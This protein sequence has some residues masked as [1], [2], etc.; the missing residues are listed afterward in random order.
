MKIYA[1]LIIIVLVGG[2]LYYVSNLQANLAIAKENV[3]KLE[4]AVAQQKEVME[5]MEADMKDIRAANDELRAIERDNVKKEEKLAKVFNQ[6]KSGAARD[7]GYLANAKPG[8]IEKVINK[9]SIQAVRCLEIATG[10][11][12]TQSELN[13]SK[14][15]EINKACPEI[16]NPNYVPP[17][18]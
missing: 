10:S 3:V 14:Y 15:N 7:I 17:L 6:S 13:A 11:E 2:G 5:M 4:N 16:A 1:L 18:K 12:L 9:G 8:L